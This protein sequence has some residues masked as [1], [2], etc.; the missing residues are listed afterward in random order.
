MSEDKEIYQHYKNKN[1]Y[2]IEEECKIQENGVWVEAVLYREY[3]HTTIY[4][5]NKKEFF[6]KF[7]LVEG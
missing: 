5:R 1:F 7:K 3:G 6:E 4:C 2:V